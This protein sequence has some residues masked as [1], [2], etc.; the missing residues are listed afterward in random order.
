MTT[1]PSH[2]RSHREIVAGLV[3]LTARAA[4][5]ARNRIRP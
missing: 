1:G 2:H 5:I 3:T 4:E